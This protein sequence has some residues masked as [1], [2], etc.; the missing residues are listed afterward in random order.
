MLL[1]LLQLA[2][3]E[4]SRSGDT[5][6]VLITILLLSGCDVTQWIHYTLYVTYGT[7]SHNLPTT[8]MRSK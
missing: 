4:C 2:H 5:M 6:R 3:A 1:L 7:G 8:V